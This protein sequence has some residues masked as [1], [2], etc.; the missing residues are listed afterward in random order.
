MAAQRTQ[1]QRVWS[2][3]TDAAEP[4]AEVWHAHLDDGDT[5]GGPAATP[6]TGRLQAHRVLRGV[7]AGWLERTADDITIERGPCRSCGGAHG[8]P[9]VT[10]PHA[11][12]LDVS[13]SHSAGRCL[14][15]IS[16]VG[17]I[18]VDIQAVTGAERAE[19]IAARILSPD[20]AAQ[21]G[22]PSSLPHQR[23]VLGAWARKE[24]CLKA[25]GIGIVVPMRDVDVGVPPAA[26]DTPVIL[27]GH[28][29]SV[30]DI[31]LGPAWVAAASMRPLT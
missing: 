17:P 23:R 9:R 20:E 5:P 3:S 14:V 15:G 16:E 21:L 1:A 22:T 12:G 30:L 31:P 18:G 4:R 8:A 19:R 24:A 7:V 10:R 29:L 2:L 11:A 25:I 28:A 27:Q 26:R 6:R 13:L